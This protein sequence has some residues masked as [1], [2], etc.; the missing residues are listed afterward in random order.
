MLDGVP[1][2]RDTSDQRLQNDRERPGRRTVLGLPQITCGHKNDLRNGIVHLLDF[3]VIYGLQSPP[4][5]SNF[6][7]FVIVRE[8]FAEAFE[9]QHF[10]RLV[11]SLKSYF[12]VWRG[13]GKQPEPNVA[14][15]CRS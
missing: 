15:K 3:A 5:L 2:V 8:D 7:L 10:Q 11:V 6:L 14:R 4:E 13:P 9:R 12:E 1:H